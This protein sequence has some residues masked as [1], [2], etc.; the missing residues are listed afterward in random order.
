[1]FHHAALPC[2]APLPPAAL[3]AFIGTTEPSDSLRHICLSPSS[4]VRHTPLSGRGAGPPGLPRNHNVRHAMVSD[5]GEADISLPLLA[6]PVLA[7]TIGTVSPLPL[8]HFRGSFPSTIRLTACLLAVLRLKHDVTTM[9]PRTCYPV[10]GQP[11]GTGFSPARL[12]DLARP[13]SNFNP[14]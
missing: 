14:P 9:P 8:R 2:V 7:S 5:P 1:M 4:V 6:M 13:H 3:P 10:V 12:R 11:S